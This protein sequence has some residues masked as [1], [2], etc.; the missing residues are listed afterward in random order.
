MIDAIYNAGLNLLSFGWWTGIVWP[1]L[2]ILIKIV[3]ILAPLMGAVVA[4]GA[5]QHRKAGLERIE[6]AAE[7]DRAGD[8]QLD[9]ALHLC[10]GA[11]VMRQHN[12]DH[13]SVWTSTEST[14]GRFCASACHVSPA[15]AEA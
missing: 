7:G 15:S 11:Q 4:D 2:W 14:A 12:P 9:L 1:V 8:L 13:G 5:A 6:H 10:Q 3:C